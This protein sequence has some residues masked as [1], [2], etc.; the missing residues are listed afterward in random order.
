MA[1]TDEQR[2]AIRDEEFFRDQVRKEL[3]GPKQAPGFFERIS[4]FLE[5]KSGFWLLTTVL[6]GV[7]ATGFRRCSVIWTVTRSP[8]VKPPSARG[9]TWRPC[10]SSGRC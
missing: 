9:A 10:S 5:T 7:T 4:N 8:S 6:A 1:L 2:Q 3:A